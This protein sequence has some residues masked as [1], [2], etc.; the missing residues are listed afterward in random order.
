MKPLTDP[1]L[2]RY[3]R[4]LLLPQVDIEGQQK[5]LAASVLIVGAGGLGGPVAMYLAAAGVGRLYLADADQVDLGNLQR[6]IQFGQAD[7][8]RYKVNATQ[9]TV[10]GINAEVQLI[11]VI[12]R[13]DGDELDDRVQAVDLVIDCTDNFD[14]R[15]AINAACVKA[16][17]PL[18]SGAAIGFE[19]QV[20]VLAKTPESACYRCLYPQE[21]SQGTSCSESGIIAPLVGLIGSLQALEALKLLTGAGQCLDNRLFVIDGLNLQTRTLRLRKDPACPCCGPTTTA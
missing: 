5:L 19:G 2:L 8:G 18:I 4:H 17:K 6:Q 3:S 21:G 20:V 12:R 10:N 9:D 13:L 1:Q 11:P 15:F 14:S 7:I 16:G